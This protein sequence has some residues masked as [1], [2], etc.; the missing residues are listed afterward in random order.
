[1][2]TQR[3]ETISQPLPLLPSSAT[4]PS[5][6]FFPLAFFL[7]PFLPYFPPYFPLAGPSLCPRLIAATTTINCLFAS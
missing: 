5:L 6:A 7:L 1:M 3:L 2:E 4:P